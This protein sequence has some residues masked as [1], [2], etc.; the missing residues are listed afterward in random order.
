[1]SDLKKK[2]FLASLLLLTAMPSAYAASPEGYWKTIDDVTGKPKSIIQ[3]WKAENN[4]LM[5]RV[6]RL[7]PASGNPETVRR[8]TA[9]TGSLHDQPLVGMVILSGLR[10]DTVQWTHGKIL[11][12]H[13]GKTYQCTA[14]LAHGGERLKVRGYVGLPAFGRSQTWERVDLVSNQG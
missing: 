14:R 13:N 4:T 3:I 2:C 9:C 10:A 11:D 7:F 1:M 8:C 12:P 5:G 6:V